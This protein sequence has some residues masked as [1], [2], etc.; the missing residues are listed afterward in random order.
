MKRGRRAPWVTAVLA[1][2]LTFSIVSISKMIEYARRPNAGFI[3]A[4]A[5]NGPRRL[6]VFPATES[7]AKAVE[8]LDRFLGLVELNGVPIPQ[9][10]GS[11]RTPA[12][13][14]RDLVDLRPGAT[15]TFLLIDA[16]HEHRRLELPV[17]PFHFLA[18]PHHWAMLG[19][20]L[21]G[22]LY[23][24]IGVLVWWRKPGDR[25]AEAF[26]LFT[27]ISTIGMTQVPPFDG[28]SRVLS[29]LANTSLPMYG[30]T[31]IALALEFTRRPPH[32][33]RALRWSG[34]F[35]SLALTAAG[36]LIYERWSRGAP[37]W[38]FRALLL[39]VGFHLV[40]SS[41]VL[42]Y[43]SWKASKAPNPPAVRVRARIFST[44][45]AVA[46]F[47]PSMQ[48]IVLPFFEVYP[49]PLILVNLLLFGSF[50][51]VMGYAI[52]RY[53]L[54]DLRIALQ[55][56]VIYALLSLVVSL[57][58]AGLVL[59]LVRSIGQSV[60]T[61]PLFLGA[62]IVVTVLVVSLLQIRV[63]RWIERFVFRRRYV[64]GDALAHASET[65][66]RARR[67][68]DAVGMVRN[69]L[70]T[71]MEVERAAMILLDHDGGARAIVLGRDPNDD[72]PGL[73]SDPVDFTRLGPVQRA[74]AE[75][76][77]TS[78]YDLEDADTFWSQHGLEM[79]VPLVIGSGTSARPLGALLVGPRSGNRRLDREDRRLLLTLANQLTVAV[80]NAHAFEE[81]RRLKQGLEEKVRDRTRELQ[82]ALS[83][84]QEAEMALVESEKE[85]MLGR[86]IAGIVHE[87]NSPLGALTSTADTLTRAIARLERAIASGEVDQV[88]LS[89]DLAQGRSLATIQKESSQRIQT[90][91]GSLKRFVSLDQAQLKAMDVRE[92]IDSAIELIGAQTANRISIERRYPEAP[93]R[94]LCHPIKLNQVFL[95]LLQNSVDAIDGKGRIDV[96]VTAENG[97]VE[98][99][100]S[101]TGRGIPPGEL[102]GIFDVGFTKKHGRVGLRLGLPSSKR[103]IEEI[104][105]K[106]A[107]ESVVGEG[108]TVRVDIPV[109]RSA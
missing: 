46:F 90:L 17:E 89:K 55:R 91:I 42:V 29:I 24:L 85:V 12:Q 96:D 35:V 74:L 79:V 63:Q 51:L 20:E 26:L 23:L 27:L 88:R 45:V 37:D 107:I 28:L 93:T 100:F 6:L 7:A 56:S 82:H 97:H 18:L 10:D 32:R 13:I 109:A 34:L 99:S 78:R 106:L 14:A 65:L 5:P 58:Y 83:E 84:L 80:D 77:P 25:A 3:F 40:T 70:L 64:Y 1:A 108:T 60:A 9:H 44:A 54:F 59:L 49:E 57:S 47:V 104:G 52:V 68:D 86:L 53:D 81:I 30:A 73:L 4:E 94:V 103:A 21:V 22:L 33:T 8:G 48:L 75:N 15:N 66:A 38:W 105:G 62:T 50:P 69:A 101:D 2:A 41:L 87:I 72:L 61:A 102:E 95:N 43:F 76:H 98:V 71:S 19:Y 11:D 36:Y 67:I 31:G 16:A 92:G 39:A